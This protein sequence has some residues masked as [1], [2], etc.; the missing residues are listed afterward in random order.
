MQGVITRGNWLPQVLGSVIGS[1]I[2]LGGL[3]IYNQWQAHDEHRRKCQAMI[4]AWSSNEDNM[5]GLLKAPVAE[6]LN[7]KNQA[8][9]TSHLPLLANVAQGERLVSQLDQDCP[10][11]QSGAYK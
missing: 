10:K 9:V 1:V 2:L 7:A 6:A 4:A 11:W 3:I 8:P 5:E